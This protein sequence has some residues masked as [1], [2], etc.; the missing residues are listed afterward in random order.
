[1]SQLANTYKNLL[2]GHFVCEYTLP[3]EWSL[4]CDEEHR[5]TAEKWVEQLGLRLVR[6]GEDGAFF[7]APA[8][9]NNDTRAAV[10]QALESARGIV[11][12]VLPVLEALRQ[13]HGHDAHLQPG[14][15]LWES[16]LAERVRQT[17]ALE[18]LVAELDLRGMRTD[19]SSNERVSRMLA[20]LEKERYAVAVQSEHRGVRL[21]GK[22]DFLYG[23]L[24]VIAEHSD[25]LSDSGVEDQEQLRLP[26]AAPDI[27]S[28][29]YA[30]ASDGSQD[31]AE[32]TQ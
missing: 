2:A 26:D 17:P 28:A 31:S 15:V 4:L 18:Q 23:V 1:M 24:E 29:Q 19:A 14:L 3:D 8:I 6:L 12:S 22:I 25:L 7:L 27:T 9:V 21:T 13:A 20:L 32:G 10:R 11:G 30:E 16:E 5:A